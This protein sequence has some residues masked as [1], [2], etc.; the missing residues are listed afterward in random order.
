VLAEDGRQ[1]GGAVALE[2]VGI[3]ENALHRSGVEGCGGP[4]EKVAQLA[5]HPYQTNYRLP[6]RSRI[7]RSGPRA[8]K[9]PWHI[10]MRRG[11]LAFLP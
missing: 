1:A 9:S 6:R 11:Q 3:N 7:S 8:K 10:R 2:P 5:T 4:C